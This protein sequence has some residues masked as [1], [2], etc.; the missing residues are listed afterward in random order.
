MTPRDI[1]AEAAALVDE[2]GQDYGDVE[3]NF[4]NIASIA[5]A[6]LGRDL[7]AYDVAMILAAVK[8]ARMRQ[9]PWKADNF[10]DGINYLAFATTMRP[11][12]S[13]DALHDQIDM[14][15]AQMRE[16]TQQ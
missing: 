4:A 13:R 3:N 10:L 14:L 5:N 6:M 2:R 15:S 9:S 1:L 12:R 16:K 11:V 8:F 7:S